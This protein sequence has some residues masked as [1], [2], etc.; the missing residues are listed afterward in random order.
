METLHL[1]RYLNLS[2]LNINLS[3]FK[4]T[5]KSK[6]YVNKFIKIEEKNHPT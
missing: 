6:Q 1:R 3:N 4:F 2:I 5:S